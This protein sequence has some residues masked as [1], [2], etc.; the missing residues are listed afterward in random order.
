M[1]SDTTKTSLANAPH[2]M[3][4]VF[5]VDPRTG[6]MAPAEPPAR[7]PAQWEPWEVALDAALR[8]KLQL[9]DKPGITSEEKQT[10]AVWRDSVREVSH[11]RNYVWVVYSHLPNFLIYPN[12][13]W[14]Y[15]IF[16][17]VVSVSSSQSSRSMI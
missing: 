11:F 2:H 3:G 4:P 13:Y 8:V 5:D 6:F 10:S 14:N 7:L 9:G 16:T 17:L 1:D 12:F 15:F